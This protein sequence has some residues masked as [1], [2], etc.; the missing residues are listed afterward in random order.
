MGLGKFVYLSQI[1]FNVNIIH[2]SQFLAVD[3]TGM[4]NIDTPRNK[5]SGILASQGDPRYP[6][7]ESIQQHPR[8]L[9]PPQ[10]YTGCP[11]AKNMLP[12]IPRQV[13]PLRRDSA[14]VVDNSIVSFF[15]DK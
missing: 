12:P 10:A 15:A 4:N 2:L 3:A 5:I 13:P 9:Y 14:C 6:K 8:L 7:D 1:T 11:T